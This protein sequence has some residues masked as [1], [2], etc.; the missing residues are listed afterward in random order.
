MGCFMMQWATGLWPTPT[1][2]L[3]SRHA[4]CLDQ[5]I[6]FVV[7]LAGVGPSMAARFGPRDMERGIRMW[8]DCFPVKLRAIY[9][10]NAWAPIRG[11]VGMA[12][13]LL[14]KKLGE[15]LVQFSSK[16]SGPCGLADLRARLGGRIE[17]LPREW[18]GQLDY[19]ASDGATAPGVTGWAAVV[20][21][22]LR[23]AKVARTRDPRGAEPLSWWEDWVA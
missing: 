7:D 1:N 6:T 14:S 22:E 20:A 9:V 17:G 16:E 5:A 23:R 12:K 11:V 21:G 4:Q 18:G 15:R 3:Q 10:L 8:Q 2:E 19:A 13:V